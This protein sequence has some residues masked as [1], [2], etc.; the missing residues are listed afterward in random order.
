MQLV[1]LLWRHHPARR[2]R[3]RS[4]SGSEGGAAGLNATRRG[5]Q[6][7]AMTHALTQQCYDAHSLLLTA[8]C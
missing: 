2:E 3:C 5:E 1:R 4:E 7:A 6:T 8:S